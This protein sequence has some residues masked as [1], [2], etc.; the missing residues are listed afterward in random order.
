MNTI[1]IRF[2][3]R[4]YIF[5]FLCLGF[6]ILF[7]SGIFAASLKNVLVLNFTNI[8]NNKN[9]S[10]LKTSI[11]E[12]VIKM[13]KDRFVFKQT[14]TKKWQKIAIDNFLYADEYYTK[15]VAMNLGLL[16][17]QD[18]VVSGSFKVRTKKKS[19][20]KENE[21]GS[22]QEIFVQVGIFDITSKKMISH[23]TIRAPADSRIFNSIER[24]AEKITKEAKSI[25]PS[26]EEWDKKGF[27]ADNN[28]PWFTDYSI[29]I[30]LGGGLYAGGWATDLQLKQPTLSLSFSFRVPVIWEYLMSQFELLYNQHTLKDDS[31][32]VLNIKKLS[33]SATN[34]M[35][36]YTSMIETELIYNFTI[37]PK[38]SLGVLMQQSVITGELNSTT[39]NA[40]FVLGAGLDTYY[41]INYQLKAVLSTQVIMHVEDSVYTFFNNVNLGVNYLF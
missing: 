37:Y 31:S 38:F 25:L 39:T 29:G 17:K 35:I 33:L 3:L 27:N 2:G 21:N 10:Y 6:I 23:F 13:L 40:F 32:S 15:S 8:E 12:A 22:S 14:A 34:Y 41:S 9:Y 24:V 26:K 16:A 1:K 19:I 5:N 11:P 18:L 28:E 20:D 7:S 36:T 30:R 4:S